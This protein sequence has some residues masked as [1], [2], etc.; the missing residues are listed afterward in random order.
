[1]RQGRTLAC[2]QVLLESALSGH[3]A[4]VHGAHH[5]DQ[6][7]GKNHHVGSGFRKQQPIDD[8][9]GEQGDDRPP[10]G[11]EQKGHERRAGHVEIEDAFQVA[12]QCEA[13]VV[14]QEAGSDNDPGLIHQ[15]I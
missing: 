9:V 10:P 1:M 4:P 2:P 13:D 6:R 5:A 3:P 15:E 12:A 11:A 7:P 14:E 8:G